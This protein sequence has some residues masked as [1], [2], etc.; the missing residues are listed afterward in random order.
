MSHA[1]IVLCGSAADEHVQA[2]EQAL[3]Q[4]GHQPIIFDTLAYPEAGQLSLG[5]QLDAM[6]LD[7]RSITFP[8]AVYVRSFYLSPLAHM[9]DLTAQMDQNWKRTLIQLREKSELLL[10]VMQRWE[11]LGVPIYNSGTAS[12]FTRKPYQLARL[13]AAGLPVPETLWSNE[14]EAVKRFAASRRVAVKPIGGGAATRELQAD[15]L[16][17][18]RLSRL[19]AAPVTFQELLPGAD[20]RVFIVDGRIIAAIRIQTKSLDYRQAEE[21]YEPITLQP[22]LAA[23]CLRACEVI[24]LRF[25]GMDLKADAAGNFRILELNSSPMFLGFDHH[26]G[27]DILGE[28]VKALIGHT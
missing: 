25:T 5:A 17:D 6:T 26:S 12:S 22:Q 1:P 28:L 15:D 11:Q 7:G 14:P 20:M 19:A 4:R 13:A 27:S 9:V 16:S 3:V 23:I 24:G 8:R 21:G 2:L 18:E 10:A